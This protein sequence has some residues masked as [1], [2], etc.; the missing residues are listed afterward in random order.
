MGDTP[1]LTVTDVKK[2][3]GGVVVLKP[4]SFVVESGRVTA[5]AGENG[6]GKSTVLKII[7]GQ[8]RPD[9]GEVLVH[10]EPLTSSDPIAARR[11][12]V[13]IVPQELAPYLDM[14][15]YENIF[16]GREIRKA[17][18]LDRGEM[19]KQAREML[20]VFELNIDPRWRMGRLSVALVQIVEIVK[21]TTWGARVLLLD[22]PTSAIPDHEVARL[23]SVVHRLRE[24]GVAMIYTTHRMAEIQELADSVIILRDGNFIHEYPIAEADE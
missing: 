21:A 22:E 2:S 15:V 7:S 13:A 10:G 20:D 24:Q 1:A 18:M 17:G 14:T 12:G 9:Q 23:Y 5:L 8:V 11:L 4:T 16:V 3:Y 19:I 6:A